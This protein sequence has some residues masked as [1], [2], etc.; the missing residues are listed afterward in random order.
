MPNGEQAVNQTPDD[1]NAFYDLVWMDLSRSSPTGVFGSK[2]NHVT[3]VATLPDQIIGGNS[4]DGANVSY[5]DGHI[6]W[7]SQN[8]MKSRWDDGSGYNVWF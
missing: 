8:V 7:H 3:G 4:S 1:S 6:E 5:I 2:G